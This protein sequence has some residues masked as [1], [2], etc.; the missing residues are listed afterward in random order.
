MQSHYDIPIIN[1][2]ELNGIAELETTDCH[3]PHNVANTLVVDW[4]PRPLGVARVC[5]AF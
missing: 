3:E 4:F 2:D 5:V 1:V